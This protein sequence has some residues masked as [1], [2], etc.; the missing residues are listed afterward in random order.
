MA[1]AESRVSVML[2]RYRGRPEFGDECD[3]LEPALSDS[4]TPPAE[5]PAPG[6]VPGYLSFSAGTAVAGRC[7]E[8]DP[9]PLWGSVCA[10]AP[11]QLIAEMAMATRLHACIVAS[12]SSS[13]T[14]SVV[15]AAK[16]IGFALSRLGDNFV[17][18][19]RRGLSSRLRRQRR[20]VGNTAPAQMEP[21]TC[22]WGKSDGIPILE[23]AIFRTTRSTRG[24]R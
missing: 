15:S 9:L 22:S 3:E 17:F 16:A 21:G 20:A 7:G 1:A 19:A 13:P 5:C 14:P 18:P 8:Y 24:T 2:S 10:L 6:G 12:S 23:F 11:K 4:A